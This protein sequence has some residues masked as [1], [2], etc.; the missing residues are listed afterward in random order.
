MS[1]F[2]SVLVLAGV[3][4]SR[5]VELRNQV[6]LSPQLR[7][8]AYL[9]RNNFWQSYIHGGGPHLRYKLVYPFIPSTI[10]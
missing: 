7:I 8:L 3:D 2:T 6:I 9:S 1:F 5:I 4:Q 10:N